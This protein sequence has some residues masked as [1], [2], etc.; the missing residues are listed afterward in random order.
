MDYCTFGLLKR[1]LSKRKPTT[2]EGLWKVVEEE[3][4]SIPL[5]IL[6]KA[7]LSQKSRSR[8]IVQKKGYQTYSPEKRLSDRAFKKI[9]FTFLTLIKLTKIVLKM[10]KH[11]LYNR[12]SNSVLKI[13]LL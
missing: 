9:S 11:P 7:L 2:I 3:W 8:L 4:K 12:L 13:L 5:G 6:R 10:C 1:A